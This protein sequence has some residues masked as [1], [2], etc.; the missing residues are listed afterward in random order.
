MG[1]DVPV[2]LAGR[3]TVLKGARCQVIGGGLAAQCRIGKGRVLAFAD[4]ALFERD[5]PDG[6]AARAGV[7]RALLAEAAR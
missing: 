6:T 7:L 3:F 1:Q 2:N 4:A 5:V